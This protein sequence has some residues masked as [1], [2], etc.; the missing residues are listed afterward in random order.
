MIF[1]MDEMIKC[2][3]EAY[4]FGMNDYIKRPISPSRIVVTASINLY[5]R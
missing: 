3:I 1:T 5:R 4:E 2:L